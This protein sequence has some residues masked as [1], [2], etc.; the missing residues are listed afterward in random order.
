[1]ILSKAVIFLV[2]CA[3]VNGDKTNIGLRLFEKIY[4]ECQS[5]EFLLKC[6]KVQALKMTNR[7]LN[8]DKINLG[9]GVNIVRKDNT[10]TSYWYPILTRSNYSNLNRDEI[11]VLLG[12]ALNSLFTSRRIDFLP[13][14]IEEAR[15]KDKKTNF[16]PLIAAIAIKSTFMA[17]AY[18]GIMATAG[19]AMIVG[20]MALLLCAIMGLKKLLSEKGD[21]GT[22]VEIVKHPTHSVS[23]THSTSYEDDHY[24]R[25]IASGEELSYPEKMIYTYEPH[26]DDNEIQ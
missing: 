18:K 12:K 2:I 8:L 15:K 23:H 24:H 20:K 10:T 7:I 25:S 4:D 21:K 3:C 19:V 9:N 26:Q 17:L 11:D 13:S 16:G 22:T 6:F 14:S 1:M 5:S